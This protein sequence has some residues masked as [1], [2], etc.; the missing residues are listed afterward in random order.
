MKTNLPVTQTERTMRDGTIIVTK[1]D[2]KGVIT[3]CNPD[4]VE[5]SGFSEDE[6]IGRS[7]NVVRHPDVPPAIFGDLWQTIQ[8]GRPWSGVVKNRCKNGDHYWVYANVTP[9]YVGERIDGY[10]SVRTKPTRDQIAAAETLYQRVAESAT[11]E[12]LL[13]QALHRRETHPRS[14]M[15]QPRWLGASAVAAFALIAAI[16]ALGLHPALL[17]AT[18]AV[19]AAAVWAGLHVLQRRHDAF[20]HA[21]STQLRGLSAGRYFDWIDDAHEGAFGDLADALKMAQIKIGYDVVNANQTVLDVIHLNH[22]LERGSAQLQQISATI[23]DAVADIDAAASVVK[24]NAISAAQADKTAARATA[25]AADGGVRLRAAM[26]AMRDMSSFGREI[27][28]AVTLID[29]IA[30]NT[31]LL[32]LNASVEAARAGETGRGFAVVAAEVRDLAQHAA[33]AASKVK[34]LVDCTLK[35][36]ESGSQHVHESSSALH[37]VIDEISQVS[38]LMT[39]VATA[40]DQQAHRVDQLIGRLHTVSRGIGENVD[41]VHYVLALS[42]RL[43]QTAQAALEA[44]SIAARP[45]VTDPPNARGTPPARMRKA[46]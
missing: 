6:L 18:A 27:G 20:L 14:R 22:A 7:Q 37:L 43:G 26:E 46:A 10:L 32:S 34:A 21:V 35:R 39:Q 30:F 28:A 36:I 15:T 13:K 42:R 38:T 2:R 23:G 12:R 45:D 3:A 44:S 25:T 41:Q 11:P 4:F 8:A 19:A 31:R 5:I 16:G 1:T 9:L 33:E 40:D 29:E 17:A 24:E